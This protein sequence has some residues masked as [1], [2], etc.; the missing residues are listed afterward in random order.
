MTEAFQFTQ[1]LC[2]VQGKITWVLFMWKDELQG[3]DDSL[4]CKH[5]LIEH[6]VRLLIL[7]YT[8]DPLCPASWLQQGSWAD[9]KRTAEEQDETIE[10]LPLII[11]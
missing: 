4:W 1:E 3:Q 6:F 11:S 10:Y 5:L 2:D 8:K 9:V 7:D